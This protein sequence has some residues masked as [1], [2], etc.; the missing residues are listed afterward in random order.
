MEAGPGL[1]NA[2]SGNRLAL[3][4]PR[5]TVDHNPASR[6]SATCLA[7]AATLSD[8]L[9]ASVAAPVLAIDWPTR[10]AERHA[11]FRRQSWPDSLA[12]DLSMEAA[13]AQSGIDISLPTMRHDYGRVIKPA[14][15][16]AWLAEGC[17]VITD[18][19]VSSCVR[20]DHGVTVIANDGRQEKFDA[21]VLA[22]GAEMPKLLRAMA[23]ARVSR[24]ILRRDRSAIFRQPRSQRSFAWVS[25]MAAI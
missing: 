20:D 5:L 15:L 16:I 22:N 19:V 11:K 1:A 23:A 18:F 21:I 9:G 12:V 25:A 17:P 3:Q 6:L 14:K 8:R 4:S 13:S 7:F 2:A 10:E 24:L